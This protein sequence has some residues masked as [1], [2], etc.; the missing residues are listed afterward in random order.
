M[1]LRRRELRG[2]S[3][4]VVPRIAGHLVEGGK[5][6]LPASRGALGDCRPMYVRVLCEGCVVGCVCVEFEFLAV[7]RRRPHER[8]LSCFGAAGVSLKD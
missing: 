6:A 7:Q 1:L 2:G 3:V 8:G 5:P 4:E